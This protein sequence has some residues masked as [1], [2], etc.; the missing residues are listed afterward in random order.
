MA[1]D[2]QEA[3]FMFMLWMLLATGAVMTV[4]IWGLV[5][6]VQWVWS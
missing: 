5:E 6:L 1:S 4:V 2:M 3:A